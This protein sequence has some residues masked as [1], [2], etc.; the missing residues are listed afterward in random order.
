MKSIIVNM[1]L[2]ML[3]ISQA[4]AAANINIS[5]LKQGV[6]STI[7]AGST[8]GLSRSSTNSVNNLIDKQ[9]RSMSRTG[10]SGSI[11]DSYSSSS[12]TSRSSSNSG[13]STSSSQKP[14]GVK[15]FYDAGTRSSKG[16]HNYRV[17]CHNGR[18]TTSYKGDRGYWYEVSS[19]QGDKYRHLSP[20][21]FSKKYCS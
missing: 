9:N 4:V 10:N 1:L 14:T 11:N 17:K 12:S 20:S 16:Y 19:N 18:S 13:T 7:Y 21:N 15:E 3:L 2:G 5:E 6:N 8:D